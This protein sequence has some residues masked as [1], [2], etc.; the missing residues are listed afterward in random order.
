MANETGF[1]GVPHEMIEKLMR[2]QLTGH[3]TR[4]IWFFIRQCQGYQMAERLITI[5]DI[6]FATEIRRERVHEALRSLLTKKIIKRRSG[7]RPG[8]YVYQWNNKFFGRT[9]ATKTVRRD[10][11]VVRLDEYRHTENRTTLYENPDAEIRKSGLSHTENRITNDRRAATSAARRP[12]KYSLKDNKNILKRE[13]ETDVSSQEI[14][15]DPA[16]PRRILN[17]MLKEMP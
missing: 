10:P 17:D 16:W 5:E 14:N 15:Q 1:S 13:K 2:L 7:Y 4:L 11:K 12:P 6:V 8:E 3:E 9:H